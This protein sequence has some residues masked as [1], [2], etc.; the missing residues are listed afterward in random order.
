MDE[1]SEHAS[2]AEVDLNTLF[3]DLTFASGEELALSAGQPLSKVPEVLSTETLNSAEPCRPHMCILFAKIC[4][5]ELPYG[6]S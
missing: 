3:K 1:E 6:T 5:A 2:N 4:S